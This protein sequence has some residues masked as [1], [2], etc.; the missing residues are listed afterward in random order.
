MS[1]RIRNSAD[2][3]EE[4]INESKLLQIKD[5]REIIKKKFNVEPKLQRLYFKGKML[6]DDS[7]DGKPLTLFDYAVGGSDVIQLMPRAV[8]GDQR[9]TNA[10]K[11]SEKSSLEPEPSKSSA[12]AA[13]DPQPD[14]AVGLF[15]DVKCEDTEAWFLAKVLEIV[16]DENMKI[17]Y[18]IEYTEY[19]GE[20]TVP[21][22]NIR[23]IATNCVEFSDVKVGD[24]LFVNYNF[25]KPDSLGFWYDAQV[26]AVKKTTRTLVCT[27][28]KKEACR[29][30]NLELYKSEAPDFS[31]QDC[32]LCKKN[33][34]RK[35]KQCGCRKCGGKDDEDNTIMCD[36]CNG[37]YHIK[38]LGM[39][40]LP[41]EDEWFCPECKN[42]NDIVCAGG[43][44]M[45]AKERKNNSTR[46]W[47]RGQ[48][49]EGR[50]KECTI[51]PKDHFGPIPGIEV[52]MCWQYR[53]Q[54]SE[55]GIHRPPVAGISGT[56]KGHM[57]KRGCQSIVISGGYEDD[58][59][60]GDSFLYTGSGGRD[61]SGNKRTAAQSSD[62]KLD[63]FNEAIAYSCMVRPVTSKGGDA[64]DDWRKGKPVRV[65]RAYKAKKHSRFAPEEGFRYDG[66]YKVKRYWQ[67]KGE[68]GFKVWRFEFKRDDESPAPW[69]EEGQAVI[70]REGYVCIKR[71][72]DQT[73]AKGKKRKASGDEGSEEDEEEVKKVRRVYVINDEWMK[74]IK[75]D[76]RN[77]KMWDQV[78]E[79]EVYS[80]TELLDQVRTVLTCQ[81]CFELPNQQVTTVC[82]HHICQE[83]LVMSFK[84]DVFTCPSCR[85]DLGKELD[86]KQFN[87][88]LEAILDKLFPRL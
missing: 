54:V 55:E 42:E 29:V 9:P 2:S 75:Q 69:T 7:S 40:S 44:A 37:A 20:H 88:D 87:K 60:S 12:T 46:D 62:Q 5:L 57:D 27:I 23:N 84:N 85:N 19:E 50:T 65:C 22:T 43:K 61:L 83:C 82:G 6:E 63:R 35:C 31:E 86:L 56:A 52:G 3:K 26:E 78:L 71:N 17:D 64:G 11:Q 73:P 72:P 28:N 33:S 18:K 68:S 25:E 30:N 51:V 79:K 70:D 24:K 10:D 76:T 53:L 48:A 80:R 49:T 4:T 41:E 16:R 77:K 15:V 39:T 38:C 67:D 14:F 58:I 34:K 74:L 81:I 32:D 47:G 66:I 13:P 36:E 21:S 59:D 8:L 45:K 1:C